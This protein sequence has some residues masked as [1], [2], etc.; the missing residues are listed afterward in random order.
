[1]STCYP[2]HASMCIEK[3]GSGLLH[4]KFTRF[5]FCPIIQSSWHDQLLK[6]QL[7]HQLRPPTGC[8]LKLVDNI[9][10]HLFI[11]KIDLGTKGQKLEWLCSP[12]LQKAT[13]QFLLL[14]FMT[15]GSVCLEVLVAKGGMHPPGH[16]VMVLLNWKL[17]LDHFGLLMPELTGRERGHCTG[18]ND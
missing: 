17:R 9:S 8:H 7:Q 3:C 11:A 18:W 12:F 14:V 2:I 1:M 13:E 15:S 4:T 16:R 5:T 10:G 6:A